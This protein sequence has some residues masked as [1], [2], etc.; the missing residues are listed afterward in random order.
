MNKKIGQEWTE[1]RWFKLKAMALL[2][3]KHKKH[4]KNVVIKF[5]VDDAAS[6]ITL[7]KKDEI[8][9]LQRRRQSN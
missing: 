5:F 8:C 9:W 4:R 1:L 3:S 7:V 2:A 6:N